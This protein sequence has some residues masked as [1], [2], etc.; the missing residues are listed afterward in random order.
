MQNSTLRQIYHM[1]IEATIVY[2]AELI[3]A[4]SPNHFKLVLSYALQST[5]PDELS[6]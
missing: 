6:T 4:S 2:F 3:T 1:N 5:C